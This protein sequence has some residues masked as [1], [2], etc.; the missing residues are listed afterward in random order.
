MQLQKDKPISRAKSTAPQ[1]SDPGRFLRKL[2]GQATWE[3]ERGF[4]PRS[5]GARAPLIQKGQWMKTIILGIT[6][7]IAA[8][9]A[10]DIVSR[11]IKN[12][13][14]T[15]VVMTKNGASFITPLTMQTMSRNRVYVD[16]LQE[17][18]PKEVIHVNLPQ[19]ADLILI[20]PA[21]ANIIA[22]LAHGIADDMLTSMVLA[23]HDIPKLIAPAMNTRM[24]ENEATQH[25]LN[26]LEQRG[27]EV[28]EPRTAML[29]CGYEGKGAL[30][31]V[32]VIVQ[33][34]INSIGSGLKT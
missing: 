29:A 16:V 27:W 5:G 3:A 13:I 33:S 6:G 19:R 23:A 22:K 28:I 10:P 32:N 11:L 9:K 25:N 17:D 21:T 14:D 7:S 24:Y 2:L 15:H 26:I 34:T 20:A 4:P 18:D 1:L 8:Y 31:D 12:H 30:A